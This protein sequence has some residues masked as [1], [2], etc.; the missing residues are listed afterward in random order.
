MKTKIILAACM[1]LSISAVARGSGLPDIQDPESVNGSNAK[2]SIESAYEEFSE[3]LREC[4]QIPDSEEE[5]FEIPEGELGETAHSGSYYRDYNVRQ[6]PWDI[7][8][9]RVRSDVGFRFFIAVLSFFSFILF[10]L[11]WRRVVRM[12]SKKKVFVETD[13]NHNITVP[14]DLF[15]H[16]PSPKIE[17]EIQ[18]GP[19]EEKQDDAE[20]TAMLI[21]D[22]EPATEGMETELFHQEDRQTCKFTED[23]YGFSGK[24]GSEEFIRWAYDRIVN[25]DD[26]PPKFREDALFFL[27]KG[28]IDS[29]SKYKFRVDLYNSKELTEEEIES[30]FDKIDKEYRGEMGIVLTSEQEGQES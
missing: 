4:E 27:R 20:G 2:I 13:M 30:V 9:G 21:P 11:T 14:K 22:E 28:W 25:S 29:L 23:K 24:E 7:F 15:L 17:L 12:Q 19:K 6:S 8:R 1:A 18:T 26:I 10:L 16:L 3:C 5:C